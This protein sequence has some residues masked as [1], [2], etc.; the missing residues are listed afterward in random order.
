MDLRQR[1]ITFVQQGASKVEAPCRFQVNLCCVFNWIKRENLRPRPTLRPFRWCKL[2][3][4]A[5]KA[6]VQAYSDAFLREHVRLILGFI[7]MPFGMP[8]VR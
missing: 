4:T 2:D 7:T 1:V 3:W 6:Y 8:C 5:L